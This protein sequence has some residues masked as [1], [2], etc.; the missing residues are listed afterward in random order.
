MIEKLSDEWIGENLENLPGWAQVESRSAL[1]KNFVFKNF[2]AAWGFM[3][4]VA[5]LAE[6]MNHHPEWSNKYNE[7]NI[8]LTTHDVGGISKR[9]IEMAG[10]INEIS[11]G[12]SKRDL[13]MAQEIER[14]L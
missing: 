2:S 9:D 6:A 3:T 8:V 7:V 10:K 4:R 11:A 14:L 1:K 12:I 13:N 5:L